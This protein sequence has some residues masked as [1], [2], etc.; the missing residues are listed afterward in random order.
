[1]STHGNTS[2]SNAVLGA[3]RSGSRGPERQAYDS[4]PCSHLPR[5]SP[6]NGAYDMEIQTKLADNLLT[7]GTGRD[8]A[9]VHEMDNLDNWDRYL[10]LPNQP[11][12]PTGSTG[13]LASAVWNPERLGSM[14]TVGESG[15][16]APIRTRQDPTVRISHC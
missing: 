4:H 9:R 8:A 10:M 16:S 11:G 2:E 12:R 13:R 14:P 15:V 3:K 6:E 7:S 5:H 1:M